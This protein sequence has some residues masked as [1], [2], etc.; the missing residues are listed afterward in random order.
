M[1]LSSQWRITDLLDRFWQR[2]AVRKVLGG[3]GTM[4][5]LAVLGIYSA[6]HAIPIGAIRKRVEIAMA[7][8]FIVEW[9][10]DLPVILDDQ[11]QSAAIRTRL[12]ERVQWLHERGCQD[13]VLVAHSGGTIVSF[14]TLLRY[15][16]DTFKVAKLVTLGEAIKLGWR[17]EDESRDWVPGNSVRGDL[18]VN[19]PDL[20]WVDFWASYDPAPSG[21]LVE[22]DGSPLI[23]VERLSDKP[24]DPSIH[25]ESRPVTNF[26]HLGLDHGG[27]FANDE[28]FLIPLIRHLDDPN[29]DG[30]A[31]RF[32]R[33]PLDRTVRTERRRRRVALLLGWRWTALI[34][35]I[36][37]VIVA[38]VRTSLS[39]AGDAVAG[40]FGLLPGHELVSGTIDGVGNAVAVIFNS[41]GLTWIPEALAAAG[42]VVLGALIPIVA[43]FLIYGRGVNSWMAH[44]ALERTR[45]RREAFGPP[46]HPSARGEAVLLIGGLLA[47]VLAAFVVRLELLVLWLALVGIAGLVVR[48]LS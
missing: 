42:P 23:A 48:R 11:S 45:I 3:M 33:D 38:A 43:V 15:D 32:Y 25:I 41:V 2:P 12:I 21:E 5:A 9:F 26:M 35:G 10:G 24:E 1:S 14:A 6:L 19:H 13:V 37:A 29:G 36:A 34:F 17:L 30:S 16:H 20:K 8:M 31:S 28:G 18:K 27:Y 4:A 39:E 46:G 22:R 44:D 40:V 47:V 7:D